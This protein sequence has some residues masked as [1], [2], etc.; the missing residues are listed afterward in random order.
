[1]TKIQTLTYDG[2]K[3]R[4]NFDK[5]VQLHVEQH[6]LHKDLEDY[7]MPALTEDLKIIWFEQGIKTK[8]FEVI[9]ATVM[10]NKGNYQTFQ[11]VQDAYIDYYRK[12]APTDAFRAR[13]VATV[14]SGQR[15]SAPGRSA[16]RRGGGNGEGHIHQGRAGCLSSRQS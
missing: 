12:V 11:S 8:A 6:N 13:Q 5:H 14:R 2:D 9:K 15:A 3:P 1:M 4:F 10:A 16:G 7:G